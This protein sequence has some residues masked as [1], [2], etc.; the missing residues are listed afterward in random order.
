MWSA[1][2]V[3]AALTAIP[4][5]LCHQE[6]D[7]N[8]YGLGDLLGGRGFVQIPA[9]EFLM[10][11]VTGYADEQPAHRVRISGG[12]EIGKFEVTQAQ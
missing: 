11:S 1:L 6:E 5:A 9:G 8:L 4:T 2:F 3:A 7:V 12:F 10:G